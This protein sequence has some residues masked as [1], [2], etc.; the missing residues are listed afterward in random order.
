MHGAS[1][2]GGGGGGGGAPF[3]LAVNLWWTPPPAYDADEWVGGAPCD[4][5]SDG[6]AHQIGAVLAIHQRLC[7]QP[8]HPRRPIHTDALFG[9]R[10]AGGEPPLLMS[11]GFL[12]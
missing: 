2:G 5:V 4:Q 7:V 3:S 6:R 8:R 10:G 9:Q 11:A 1:I 12:A